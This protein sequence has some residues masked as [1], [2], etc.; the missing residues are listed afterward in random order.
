MLPLTPSLQRCEAATHDQCQGG[1]LSWKKRGQAG[2]ED[3]GDTIR[4]AKH[5]APNGTSDEPCA[6]SPYL[7]LSWGLFSIF[8]ADLSL[9]SHSNAEYYSNRE[10]QHFCL[11]KTVSGPSPDVHSLSLPQQLCTQAA[12]I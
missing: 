1:R 5:L 11:P 3:T 9:N 4:P 6:S 10:Y 12:Y 2:K 8:S 7:S